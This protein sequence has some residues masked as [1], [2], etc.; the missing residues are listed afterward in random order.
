MKKQKKLAEAEEYNTPLE[1]LLSFLRIPNKTYR[2][3]YISILERR[4]SAK[5]L[6]QNEIRSIVKM[7][8]V[9]LEQVGNKDA[10]QIFVLSPIWRYK[11]GIDEGAFAIALRK[12][13]LDTKEDK[14][15]K[16]NTKEIFKLMN[17]ICLHTLTKRD[18][19]ICELGRWPECKTCNMG[20]SDIM[21]LI[22]N[23]KK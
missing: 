17:G 9:E 2:S 5:P 21:G 1:V 20:T 11:E 18:P 15:Q 19:E 16:K 7:G 13:H 6:I 4:L 14:E 3:I 22:K 23:E 12:Y 10:N 8:W